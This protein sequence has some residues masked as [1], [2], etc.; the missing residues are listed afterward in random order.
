M[1]NMEFL[2][3]LLLGGLAGVGYYVYKKVI[4]PIGNIKDIYDTLKKN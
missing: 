3:P 4:E 2:M 1:K